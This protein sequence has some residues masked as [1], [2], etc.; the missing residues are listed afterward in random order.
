MPAAVV[1][2][3]ALYRGMAIGAMGIVAPISAVAAAIP[4]VVGVASGERPGPLQ[5]AGIVLAL[6]GVALASRE[7]THLGGGSAA[8]VGLA[9]LAATGFGFYFVFA[10]RAADESVPWAVVTAR[11][12]RSV[13]ALGVALSV[14]VFL[15]PGRGS[16]PRSSPS[17]SATSGRTSSSGWPRHE[18][19]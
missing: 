9:L 5:I 16:C 12:S 17:A 11:A 19:S 8:G 10:D 4:F 2:I 3:A 6:G 1:G 14:G 18:A 15:R 7:P 13:I